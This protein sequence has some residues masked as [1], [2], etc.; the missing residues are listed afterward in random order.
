MKNSWPSASAATT[1]IAAMSWIDSVERFEGME[2]LPRQNRLLQP[3]DLIPAVYRTVKELGISRYARSVSAA[4]DRDVLF[5]SCR[6]GNRRREGRSHSA[7]P[8][9]HLDR[10]QDAARRDRD[11]ASPDAVPPVA[12]ALARPRRRAGVRRDG[13]SARRAAP[14]GL[15]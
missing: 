14:A 6:S 1:R 4:G 13:V 3:H 5:P 11:A 8:R 10:R 9:Q 12:H 7:V 15:V 2:L